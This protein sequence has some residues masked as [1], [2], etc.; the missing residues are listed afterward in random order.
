MN[1][2]GTGAIQTLP[3]KRD[4]IYGETIGNAGEPFDWNKGFDIEDE[5]GHPIAPKNQNGSYSCGGQAGAYYAQ[6]ANGIY[7]ENYT[8]KSAKF[9]YAPIFVGTGGS[10][11]RDIMSRLI[12]AGS[13]DETLCPSYENG[14]APSEP[15][16]QRKQDITEEA[17]KDAFK[18][19]SSA[20]AVVGRDI[21]ALAKAI[22]DNKGCIIGITG[23]DNGTWLT[24][25]P[26]APVYG[27]GSTWNHWVYAGKAKMI[28]GKKYI[29]F[30]NS[31]GNIGENGW[32]YISEEW[33]NWLWG[34]MTMVV[35]DEPKTSFRFTKD[36]WIG[37]KDNEVL[38]LQKFLNTNGFP[39]AISGL[40]SKGKETNYFG[41]LT[42]SAFIRFQKAHKIYPPFGYFG[43]ISRGFISKNYIV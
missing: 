22:R 32:Q 20:Y 42:R 16:M 24:A 31:W 40:G 28:D 29:G 19:R 17:I 15:F 12:N 10:A 6:V 7:D 2:F 27:N 9:I 26:K 37:V 13:A 41:N 21:D 38:E 30:I 3:D 8:E 11:G 36:L 1:T 18:D 23:Q 34:I 25:F 43:K 14:Q 4:F 5:L 35:L 33:L 39:V